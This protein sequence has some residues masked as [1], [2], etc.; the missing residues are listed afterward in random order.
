MLMFTFVCVLIFKHVSFTL[1]FYRYGLMLA[2]LCTTVLVK[3]SDYINIIV[4]T[5]TTH[6]LRIS[7]WFL[8]HVLI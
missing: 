6:I 2:H 3:K 5:L 1:L 4:T 7:L 8:I